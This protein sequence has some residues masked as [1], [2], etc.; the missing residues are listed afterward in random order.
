MTSDTKMAAA[1]SSM[2]AG[3]R[4]AM[5]VRHG[6]PL[7]Q[8]H[9]QVAPQQPAEKAQILLEKRPIQAQLPADPGQVFLA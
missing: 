3:S 9:A 2:V 5:S 1:V 4:S 6:L 7:H 8:R